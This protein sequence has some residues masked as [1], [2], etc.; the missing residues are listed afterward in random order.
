MSTITV[1]GTSAG[2]SHSAQVTVT[3]N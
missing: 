2:V 3:V 1:T